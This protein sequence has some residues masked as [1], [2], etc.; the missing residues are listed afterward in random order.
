MK[1]KASFAVLAS[2]L[3]LAAGHASATTLTFEDLAEGVTLS[4][5]YAAL[6]AIFT[7]NAFT[8]AGG[9]TGDWATNTDMTITATDVGGL[10]TPTLVSGKVLHAFGTIYPNAGWLSEDGDASFRITFTS[11][12]SFIS[13]AFAGVSTPADVRL[14]AFNGATQLANVTSAVTT[15]Q[16]TLSYSAA[17]ITSVIIT[18]GSF[19][20]WVGVDNITYTLAAVPEASTYAMMGAGL[21]LLALRRRKS[22]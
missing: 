2:A 15:G 1:L 12:V 11:P 9:P 22:A 18:P 7:P 16:F 5:Q 14:I 21:A 10:G 8:G 20:D 3:A 4:N 6:G 19:N 17:A 13:A